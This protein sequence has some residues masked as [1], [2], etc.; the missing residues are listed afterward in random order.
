MDYF[1]YNLKIKGIKKKLGII[2]EIHIYSKK[3][4]IA[5]EKIV[6]KYQT[7]CFEGDGLSYTFFRE[8]SPQLVEISY[9]YYV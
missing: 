7:V 2:G 6:D 1:Q 3:E 4:S 8:D 5:A 9:T